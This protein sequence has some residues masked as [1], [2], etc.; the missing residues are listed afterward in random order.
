MPAGDRWGPGAAPAE[1]RLLLG[2]EHRELSRVAAE[3]LGP[4]AIALS[5]GGARKTYAH[6]DPNE[7][8]ALLVR[9]PRG[10]LLAVAD[11]HGGQEGSEIALRALSELSGPAWCAA[12]GMDAAGW[13]ENALEVLAAAGD[14]ILR[15]PG[16]ARTRPARTTLSLCLARPA[17]GLLAAASVGDSHVFHVTERGV[18]ELARPPEPFRF[19]GFTHETAES[20]D[21]IAGT[22]VVPLAGTRAVV[23]ATD[24]LSEVG[25]GVDDPEL[26][27]AEA[28]EAALRESVGTRAMSLA[29]EVVRCALEAHVAH[30]AGDN[31]AIAALVPGDEPPAGSSDPD[32]G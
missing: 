11:G 23:L 8:A 25:I 21:A 3:Q 32:R 15:A 1:Y 27:V 28:S 12:E 31:V 14:A 10:I 2:R 9:G 13:R 16:E 19:L 6:T 29:R 24:G 5:R 30:R 4:A 7:D 20:L 18:R 17:E 26:A 22:E